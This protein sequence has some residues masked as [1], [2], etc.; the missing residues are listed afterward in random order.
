MLSHVA[1]RSACFLVLCSSGCLIAT[2]CVQQRS[3]GYLG[4]EQKRAVFHRALRSA[5]DGDIFGLE[6]LLS[7]N[8]WLI[9]MKKEGGTNLLM[10]ASF[11][12]NLKVVEALVKRGANVNDVD[13]SGQT[14]LMYA[15]YSRNSSVVQYLLRSGARAKDKDQDGSSA[16]SIALE[17]REIGRNS[18]DQRRELDRIVGILEKK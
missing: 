2:G 8:G 18:E 1:K 5:G 10:V 7:D 14:A 16:V 17:L 11:R 13:S 12:G 15:V 3:Q 9:E 4:A 6:R